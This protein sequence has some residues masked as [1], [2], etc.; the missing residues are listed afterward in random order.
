MLRADLADLPH[1]HCAAALLEACRVVVALKEKSRPSTARQVTPPMSAAAAPPPPPLSAATA[2]A[3][4]A[5]IDLLLRE[6]HAKESQV[7]KC[8]LE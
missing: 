4:E 1:R 3:Y 2:A 6:L 8:E 5:K 7:L